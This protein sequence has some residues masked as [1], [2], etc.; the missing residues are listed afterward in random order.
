MDEEPDRPQAPVSRYRL[1]LHERL[2]RGGLLPEGAAD[3]ADL[4]F[5]LVKLFNRM[6]QDFES[7]HRPLGWTWAGFRIMNLLWVTGR[8]EARELAR[9]SGS[10]RATISAVL[11]TLERDGLVTRERSESDRRQ[12]LVRLTP[13]G[14]RRLESGIEAQV[15]RDRQWFAVLSDDEQRVFGQL[16]QRLA[17]Q[18]VMEEDQLEDG[19]EARR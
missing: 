13:E 19:A 8:I 6:S 16:L 12:V 11:G 3:R 17:D 5:N 15:R 18:A 4:I 9:V 14:A 7:V 10:S 2:T 1:A